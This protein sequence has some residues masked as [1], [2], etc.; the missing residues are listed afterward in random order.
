MRALSLAGLAVLLLPVLG[1]ATP[2]RVRVLT[3]NIENDADNGRAAAV[4]ELIRR[5][6]ADVVGLQEAGD[7]GAVIARLLGFNY[8]KV[9]DD[10]AVLSRFALTA[11]SPGPRLVTVALGDGRQLRVMDLHLLYKPYQPYQLLRIPYDGPDLSTEA[12][13][14]DW[15]RRTRG[16]DVEA[17]I[18][19]LDASD[20]ADAPTVVLGDFNEP[21]HLDWTEAAARV[22]R[23]PLKVA[24]PQTSAF[25]AA[26]FKDAYR[27][28]N[29]DE[30]AKPGFTWT[31]TTAPND[32]KDHHDRIDFVLYRG[33]G[34]DARRA[35]IVGE[36]AATS[37][38]VVSPYPTDHRGVAAD[39]TLR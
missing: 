3:L 24:W 33:Q 25:A 21:S 12:E 7:N 26:G 17:A 9:G 8:A 27:E 5:C 32:P 19:E 1:C 4:A 18:R 22:G 2:R 34:L 13:A 37:D 15:A 14:I 36:S 28:L 6:G 38:I 16:A 23:H 20:T 29:P 30:L 35:L 11:A 10:T 31:P 39:F